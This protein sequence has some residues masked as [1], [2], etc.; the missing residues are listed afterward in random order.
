[1]IDWLSFLVRHFHVL[2]FQSTHLVVTT[3]AATAAAANDDDDDDD[4]DLVG[5]NERRYELDDN[6]R[7]RR[8]LRSEE[9]TTADLRQQSS[10][11]DTGYQTAYRRNARQVR[12][13]NKVLCYDF[14]LFTFIA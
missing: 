9:A 3:V 10:V 14:I 12:Q 2:H 5:I 4:D 7:P 11:P 6:Q 1:M 8:R 13:T